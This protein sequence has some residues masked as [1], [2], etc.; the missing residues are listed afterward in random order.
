MALVGIAVWLWVCAMKG[1]SGVTA[2]EYA[3]IASLI[4]VT[5]IAAVVIAGNDLAAVF[6]N[7]MH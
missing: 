3:L 1:P 6:V 2:V 7:A 4:A 5:I